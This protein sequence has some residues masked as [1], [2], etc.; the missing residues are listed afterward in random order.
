MGKKKQKALPPRRLRMNRP[1]RLA[2]VKSTGWIK[3]YSGKNIIRGYRKW[4]GVDEL[5]ALIE[6]RCLGVSISEEREEQIRSTISGRA[7]KKTE[8]KAKRKAEQEAMHGTEELEWCGIQ[9]DYIAGYTAG[10]APYGIESS[11]DLDP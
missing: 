11:S 5:T 4:Y 2:N 9:F 6:L 1:R 7:N 3:K 10:G 8:L